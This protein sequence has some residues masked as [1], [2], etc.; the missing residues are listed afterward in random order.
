MSTRDPQP[1][2][3]YPPEFPEAL[4][5]LHDFLAELEASPR[6]EAPPTDEDA[7]RLVDHFTKLWACAGRD[8]SMGLVRSTP[9]Q[10]RFRE[11]VGRFFQQSLHLRRCLEKPRGYT[12]DFLMME[13]ISVA[14]P[15]A[16]TP[17]GRWLDRWFFDRFPPYL[18]VRNRVTLMAGLLDEENRRG[19]RRILNVASG[20]A[21]ELRRLGRETR[22]DRIDLVDQDGAAMKYAREKLSSNGGGRQFGKGG[23]LETHPLSARDLIEDDRV[24]VDTRYDVIYS[25]GLYDYLVDRAAGSLNRALWERLAP[26]GLL[27]VGNFNGHHWARYVM[28]AVMDWFLVYR[29]PADLLRLADRLGPDGEA[30]ILGDDTGLLGMLAVR[31]AA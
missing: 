11:K 31:K 28:E 1:T 6:V 5:G 7:S 29:D 18:S 12:G 21:V 10:R 2:I 4:E 8:A 14:M 19:A 30:T 26:G 17:L 16:E 22:F 23:I 20:A 9:D 25:M 3:Y 24:L 27:V 13:A 15:E